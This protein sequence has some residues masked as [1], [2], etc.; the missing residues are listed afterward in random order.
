MYLVKTKKYWYLQLRHNETD[1]LIVFKVNENV[2]DKQ[3]QI[4]LKT[5]LLAF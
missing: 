4:V 3:L 2:N 5:K 1:I